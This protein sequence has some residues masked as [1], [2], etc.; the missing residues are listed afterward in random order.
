MTRLMLSVLTGAVMLAPTTGVCGA[1]LKLAGGGRAE[2]P[3][4]IDPAATVVER[5]AA[6]ELVSLLKQ[7]TGATFEVQTATT[8]PGGPAVLVGPGQAASQVAPDLNLAGLKPDG[9]VILTRGNKLVLAGD[10]PRGTLYAVYQFLEDVVGCRWWSSKVSTIPQRPD[11]VV[12][13]QQVRYVPPLEYRETFWSDAFDADWAARNKSNGAHT[14]LDDQRGGKVVYGGPSFVH[15][16]APMVPP[17]KYFKDHPEWFS[18]RDGKRL[19]GYAQLCVTNEE[20]KKFITAKVLE[21]LRANPKANIVSVSQNDCDNHCLCANCKKL[22]EAEGSPMGPLLHLVNHVAAAVAKDYPDVAID[23]LAYQYTRKPPLQVRPLPNVIIRLCSIECDF[24]QPLTAPSNK[25]FADDIRGWSKICGRL[26]IWDY[27]TNFAHYIQPHPNVRVLGP[28]ARF[29]VE[30]G[31]KGIFEQ[32]AY[33]SLGAEFAELKAWVLAKVLWN[34]SLDDRKLI[35]EFVQGYYGAAAPHISAYLKLICDEA[36]ATKTYLTCFSSPTAPFLNL[37]L[38]AKAEQLFDQAEAAAKDDPAVLQRVKVARLPLRYV[39]TLRRYE[40]ED[41]AAREKLTWPGPADYVENAK[42]FLDLAK[43]AGITMVSEGGPLAGFERRTI[44]LGRV[45][46][47][48]PPGCETLP[49][50][51]WV[52]LQDATFNLYLEGTL[53][54]MEKDEAAS[55]KTAARIVGHT[56][57]WAVQQSLMGRPLK[58]DATYEVYASIRVDKTGNDGVAFTAGAYDSK[59]ARSL[60]DVAVKCADIP[61]GAYHTYKIGTTKLHGDVYLWAAPAKNGANVKY[62]WVDRFWLVRQ[63]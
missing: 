31:V 13:D 35:E 60:A 50:D 32:G 27:T 7:V 4:V 18:E 61:D 34:P 56:N 26:Y 62:V 12:P 11:L 49:R 45:K 19:D 39:W 10:R 42:T 28:N 3:V 6:T 2:C 9:L 41:Q 33:T 55:D 40:W 14:R 51:R 5:H 20:V 24:A 47:P 17:E 25:A 21:Y 46:S 48:P 29:F 53:S 15:T 44:A 36:E 23:T 58:A 38:M 63:P 57:E 8:A 30:H 43:A 16:F 1:P 52:D 59:N 37:P 54:S 22:E